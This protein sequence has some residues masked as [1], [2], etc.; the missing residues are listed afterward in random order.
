MMD[1][2]RFGNG[3]SVNNAQWPTEIANNR[4]T[5][6]KPCLTMNRVRQY[7]LN[8]LNDSRNNKPGIKIN[9]VG[10]GASFKAAQIYEGI[11]RHIEY[12][13]N[14]QQAYDAASWWQVYAGLGWF[15]VITGYANDNSFDQEI[16]IQRVA[17]AMSVYLDP[18]IHEYDGSDAKWGFVF[19]DMEQ[20]EFEKEY[21][22]YKDKVTSNTAPLATDDGYGWATRDTIRICEYF[23]KVEDS[24]VL[25]HMQDGSTIKEGDV[26]NSDVRNMV[27]QSSV[28][29]REIPNHKIEWFLIAG[30]EVVEKRDW[31]G[32]YIPLCRVVGEETVIDK[33]L[34]RKGHVRNITDAQRAYNY[35]SSAG[36]EFVA[37]QAKTPYVAP[38]NAIEGYEN[39][40][41]QANTVNLAVLP[42]N[43]MDD[44]GKE[45]PRP[46]REQAPVFADAYLKGM[47]VAQNEMAMVSG[48]FEASLGMQG[49]ER[50]G[51]AINE[52][53]RAANTATGH[54]VD[55][56]S[57]SIRFCGKIV[58]DLIPKIYDTPRLLK[59]LNID[60]TQGTVALDPNSPQAHQEIPAMPTEPESIDPQHV[61]SIFNPNIGEYAVQADVGPSYQ[62]S[63]LE[64]FNAL[65]DIMAQ[66][67]SMA[68]LV[69]DVW[70]QM[71]DFPMADVLADRFRRMLP[72]QAQADH[73]DPRMGQMQQMLAQ[74]HQVMQQQGA[75]LEQYKQKDKAKQQDAER[76][77][78]D[79]ETKR[80][81]AVGGI[82]PLALRPVVRSLVSEIL[83]MNA[84]HAIAMHVDEDARMHHNAGVQSPHAS[85][86]PPPPMP[87]GPDADG[88]APPEPPPGPQEQAMPLVPQ[89]Q[90]PPGQAAPPA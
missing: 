2:V 7:C 67:E 58:L 35:Y 10:G 55:H 11:I 31:P 26:D 81:T 74:Q 79:S 40:W 78:Y 47:T 17:D 27:R 41:K 85:P 18:T 65:S 70:A 3:D 49:N 4:I 59:I 39:E 82:D 51:K 54:Y 25:H 46:Q 30:S 64:S 77:W 16:Y 68:P 9:P 50:S 22:R 24:D 12:I 53:Q 42:Y 86:L 61:A 84:N 8:I 32:K 71:G 37:L 76:D 33:Q 23:R 44:D 34:D 29:R 20:D 19:R 80:L 87:A 57:S 38:I 62:T 28:R 45:I 66:N 1:D 36:I 90:P 60:G 6:D 13:S 5:S 75:E 52:R 89:G 88:V 63:R 43:H 56:L 15:R 73:P 48:Q 14:A 69:M 72:P 21:P 83:G